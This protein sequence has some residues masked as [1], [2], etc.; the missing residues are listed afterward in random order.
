MCHAVIFCIALSSSLSTTGTALA[1]L[2]P[3]RDYFLTIYFQKNII[4]NVNVAKKDYIFNKKNKKNLTRVVNFIAQK[5][6]IYN[7]VT[8]NYSFMS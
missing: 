2:N 4:F 5:L 6:I 1:G 8:S 7:T 3:H